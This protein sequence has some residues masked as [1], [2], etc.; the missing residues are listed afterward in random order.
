MFRTIII[1]FFIKFTRT[2]PYNESGL[3][4]LLT[5]D[6]DTT[7]EFLTIVLPSKILQLAPILQLSSIKNSSI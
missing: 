5:I 7:I 4:F 3:I 6:K 1:Y 2:P